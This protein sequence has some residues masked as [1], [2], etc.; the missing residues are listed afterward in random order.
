M[1]NLA[2]V[3]A[4]GLVA[5]G[6]LLNLTGCKE[7]ADY[8]KKSLGKWDFDEIIDRS[9]TYS[10]KLRRAEEMGGKIPMW[11]ADMDFRTAPYVR[12]ALIN[13]VNRDVMGYTHIPDEYYE[14]I[15]SWVANQQGWKMERDWV[16]YCPGVIT[17]IASAIDCFSE[18]GD[19]VIV[20]PPVY[21]PFMQFAEGLGRVVVNNPLILEDGKYQMD[22]DQL[23]SIMDDKTKLLIL[24]NPHNPGGMMWDKEILIRVAEIC[25]HHNV[26]VLSDEIHGD[27]ALG[28]RRHIPFC[29]VSEDAA[30]VGMI[31]TGPT[32]AFNI[33]G[34]HTAQTYIV[35]KELREKYY[36][37]LG[38]RK[39]TE[40]SVPAIESTIAAYSNE[41][42]WLDDLKKYLQGNIDYVAEFL[43]N[44]IPAIKAIKPE[45]SFLL[46]LDCKE[47]KLPQNELVS[48]F[49]DKANLLINSGETYREGG[50]GFIRI[51]IGCP[52]AICRKAME[53]LKTAVAK[54]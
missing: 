38:K 11:I 2:I 7:A 34:L 25:A 43:A 19:K 49:Q 1:N 54:L 28:G 8:T 30:K 16:N 52:R 36:S 51:N 14:S 20:Q 23:E 42:L 40:A 41:P 26:I 4:T 29:S 5:P 6:T 31:F 47:L 13:R 10:I 3:G 17:G 22:F 32:K 39:M 27:L 46:W 18:P 35:N 53:N 50:T 37:Y 45:A 9:G 48:L 15:I 24:C 33:A 44:E 21:N 12:E